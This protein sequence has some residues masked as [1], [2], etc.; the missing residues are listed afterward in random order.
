MQKLDKYISRSVLSATF[1]VGIILVGLDSLTSIIDET[2]SITEAYNLS[3]IFIFVG[4]TIPRRIH[5]FTPYAA[6]IG[7]MVGLG[8]LAMTSEL[9]VMRAAGCS[10]ARIIFAVLKP[11]VLVAIIGFSVGE[12]VAPHTEQLAMS[13]RALAQRSE[14]YVS[15]RFGAWNRDGNTFVH[16]HAVQRGGVAYGFTLLSFDKDLR[17][18]QSLIADR[19]THRENHWLLEQVK[20]TTLEKQ[21]TV[22]KEETLWRWDTPITPQLLTLD[23][24][25]PETLPIL[26][27]WPYARYLQE[28]G[29]V[30]ADIELVFWRKVFQPIAILGLVVLAASFVFGPL[31]SGTTGARVF[32]GVIIGVVFQISQD[33]FG[34]AS[35]IFGYEPIFAALTPIVICW[36]IGLSLLRLKG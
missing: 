6:L 26:Q 14:S 12:F 28:Q 5:E 16:V 33:F 8:R 18:T 27:L 3:D 35:L 17:L 29:M 34:P 15:G 1:G 10:I 9:T 11:A 4:Y 13:H 20:M 22:V 24:V 30:F 25:E 2:A 31:R 7:S 36:L 19:G 21:G 32:V 23:V